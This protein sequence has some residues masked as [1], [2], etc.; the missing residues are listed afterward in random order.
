MAD[1]WELIEHDVYTTWVLRR[2]GFGALARVWS[3]AATHA[4]AHMLNPWSFVGCFAS[5][6]VAA[7]YIVEAQRRR[8]L[9]GRQRM[10]A[11]M[12]GVVNG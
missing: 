1:R 8:D 10:L 3:S 11:A 9:C 2:P 4:E 12:G 5:M 6:Q 7:E